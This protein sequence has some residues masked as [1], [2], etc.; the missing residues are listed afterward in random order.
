[1]T[2]P[3]RVIAEQFS[4]STL[5]AS[6]DVDRLVQHVLV[7]HRTLSSHRS[8]PRVFWVATSAVALAAGAAL[9]VFG[10][11]PTPAEPVPLSAELDAV[12]G[13]QLVELLP[14][15]RLTVDGKGSVGG[16]SRHPALEW[17]GGK[18]E[19]SVDKGS[20]EG[21]SVRTSEGTVEVIGTVFAV[22]RRATGTEV[23]VRRGIV[24]VTCES[25]QMHRLEAAEAV[26]CLPTT[27]GG[28]LGRARALASSNAPPEQVRAALGAGLLLSPSAPIET[29]LRLQ[30]AVSLHQ[31]GHLDAAWAAVGPALERASESRKQTVYRTALAIAA[32]RGDCDTVAKLS[33]S[34]GLE[35]T[36]DAELAGCATP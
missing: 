31:S 26:W 3:Q 5:A 6:S 11:D 21:F 25:G 27:A 20:V 1:M 10:L 16:T 14:G 34:P 30:L 9:A 17:T 4:Q 28:M 29:E 12:D 19:V 22:E 32:A 33:V 7:K 35:G 2:D 36:V 15:V 24:Q 23:S 18:V 13:T 8:R